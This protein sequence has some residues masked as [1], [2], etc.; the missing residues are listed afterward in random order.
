MGLIMYQLRL[1]I[2]IIIELFYLIIRLFIFIF[3]G[4]KW[5]LF[6][7]KVPK[8]CRKK[9]P[10]VLKCRSYKKEWK[11]KAGCKYFK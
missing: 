7:K 4:K 8:Y 3:G 1:W 5:R 6:L 11:C 2:D 9:C 10:D